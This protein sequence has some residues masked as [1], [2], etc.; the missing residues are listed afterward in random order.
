[1]SLRLCSCIPVLTWHAGAFCTLISRL[2]LSSFAMAPRNS[3]LA[4]GLAAGGY[5]ATQAFVPSASGPV[6]NESV[7][8]LRGTSATQATPSEGF[9]SALP[10]MGL[11][12][13]G[14]VAA[15]RGR[16]ARRAEP[17]TAA[18]AAV[19]AA[20]AAA[21]AK[22][23][24]AT[25]SAVAGSAG[26][27]SLTKGTGVAGKGTGSYS[28]D[29]STQ[30]GAMAPLGYFDPAGLCKKGDEATFR[31][32]RAAELKHGRVA[33]MAAVGA[34]AQH[35]VKFPG[36][37]S[38]PSGLAASITGPGSYGFVALFALAGI[39]ELGAWTESDN[40]EPGNFG[41]PLGFSQY[42]QEWRAAESQLS[43]SIVYQ[44]ILRVSH[45]RHVF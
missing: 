30:I 39:L 42:T 20:K 44:F 36:F 16:V 37:E 11:V 19:A 26:V 18:A 43:L 21:A 22:G 27:G 13:V 45:V 2:T 7:Q 8:N 32:L 31:Q 29:P 40:K 4:A 35:Y 34:V 6:V 15:G 38:V 25:T 14:A 33:M 28:F 24:T 5:V 3:M 10:L 41:D 23:V 17:A 12:G 1:M 9:G